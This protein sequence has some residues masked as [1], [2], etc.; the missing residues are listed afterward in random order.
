MQKAEILR[1]RLGLAGYKLRT[2]QTSVP[3]S[4]LQRKPLPPST[5]TRRRANTFAHAARTNTHTRVRSV[6][7]IPHVPALSQESSVLSVRSDAVTVPAS[8]ESVV[9]ETRGNTPDHVDAQEAGNERD[10][11]VL[12]AISDVDSPSRVFMSSP[13]PAPVSSLRSTCTEDVDKL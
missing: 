12:L 9:V 3:L 5:A 2:G 11:T 1:L 4:E 6:G 10:K 7:S 13:A 8:Q